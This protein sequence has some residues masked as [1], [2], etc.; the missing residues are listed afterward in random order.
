MCLS[1]LCISRAPTLTPDVIEVVVAAD[2]VSVV[3]STFTTCVP[4]QKRWGVRV[5]ADDG[6]GDDDDDDGDDDD[7]NGVTRSEPQ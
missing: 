5:V 6:D 7:D 3:P 4:G 1:E 2:S